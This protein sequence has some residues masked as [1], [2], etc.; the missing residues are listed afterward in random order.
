MSPSGGHI[1]HPGVGRRSVRH[2]VI[3]YLHTIFTDIQGAGR[4]PPPVRTVAD[5][6]AT[7]CSAE[8]NRWNDDLPVKRPIIKYRQSQRA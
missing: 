5:A 8:H 7:G 4:R 3:K 2:T 1:N 6:V